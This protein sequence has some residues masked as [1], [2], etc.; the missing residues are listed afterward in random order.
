ML[1]LRGLVIGDDSSADSGD[2]VLLVLVAKVTLAITVAGV[3]M[4]CPLMS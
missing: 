3:V 4:V 1:M 2:G